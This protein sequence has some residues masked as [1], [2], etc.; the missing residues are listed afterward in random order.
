MPRFTLR[1]AAHF[2]AAESFLVAACCCSPLGLWRRRLCDIFTLTS[3][4]YIHLCSN[5]YH[6]RCRRKCACHK[7]TPDNAHMYITEC[8]STG[9]QQTHQAMQR[10]MINDEWTYLLCLRHKISLT[11]KFPKKKQYVCVTYNKLAAILRATTK[12]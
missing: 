6:R 8:C 12:Q 9:L 10:R 7:H 1:R 5:Y 2:L 3:A 11:I 4:L